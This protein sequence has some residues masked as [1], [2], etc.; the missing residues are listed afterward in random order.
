MEEGNWLNNN[1]ILIYIIMG[2]L[3]FL[4]I[5]LVFCRYCQVEVQSKK[6]QNLEN[7][8]MD[9]VKFASQSSD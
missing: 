4:L 5:I 9:K 6:S 7:S 1:S 3:F 8:P 2:S